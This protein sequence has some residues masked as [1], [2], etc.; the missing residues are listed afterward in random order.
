MPETIMSIWD[1]D[2]YQELVERFGADFHETIIRAIESFSPPKS[3][4][5]PGRL[6]LD[7]AFDHPIRKVLLHLPD[8]VELPEHYIPAMCFIRAAVRA[9]LEEGADEQ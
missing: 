7:Q 2:E 5:Y 9:Y 4:H 3:L 6:R 8:S 1:E